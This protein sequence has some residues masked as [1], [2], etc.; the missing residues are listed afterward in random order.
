MAFPTAAHME[1][2]VRYGE[3]NNVFTNKLYYLLSAGAIA[4]GDMQGIADFFQAEIAPKWRAVLAERWF[5]SPVQCI[6]RDGTTLYDV[7]ATAGT[8]AG[9]VEDSET[10]PESSAVVIRRRCNMG[11]RS[12]R[13]RVFIGC[14]P[15]VFQE[16]S[17]L[18]SAAQEAYQDIGIFMKT[19]QEMPGDQVLVPHT[20]NSKDGVFRLVTGTQVVIDVLSR[21]DRRNPKAYLVVAA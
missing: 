12:N 8:L 14:V 2:V 4:S 5:L 7:T 18:T 21:R 3:T 19:Q 20:P 1:V 6:W 15:E 9:L 16:A 17:R 13:G 10:L 11:G